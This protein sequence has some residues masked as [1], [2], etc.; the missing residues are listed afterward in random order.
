MQETEFNRIAELTRRSGE[1]LQES[2]GQMVSE[3]GEL[4]TE[5]YMP[6][7]GG[8]DGVKGESIDVWI[9]A[10]STYQQGGGTY[11]AMPNDMKSKLDKWENYLKSIGK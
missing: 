5:I 1:T 4:S 10:V 8:P 6:H 2:F 9:T 3:V 7:R 11:E